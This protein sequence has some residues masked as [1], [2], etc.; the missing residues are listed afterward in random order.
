MNGSGLLM[1]S[2]WFLGLGFRFAEDSCL[3]L[4]AS[5]LVRSRDD[6]RSY[7]SIPSLMATATTTAPV[8]MIAPTMISGAA[9]MQSPTP[10]ATAPVEATAHLSVTSRNLTLS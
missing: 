2:G 4:D 3:L 7:A 5:G 8:M 6:L 1:E 10:K 9:K